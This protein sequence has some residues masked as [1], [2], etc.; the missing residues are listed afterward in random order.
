ML[1]S[2]SSVLRLMLENV[3]LDISQRPSASNLKIDITMGDLTV[4][5]LKTASRASPKLVSTIKKSQ[6]FDSKLLKFSLEINPPEDLDDLDNDKGSLYDRNLSLTT[7]P[8]E[9]IY[10]TKTI[11]ALVDV[12]RSPEEI[13]VDYLQEAAMDGIKEYKDVKMSQVNTRLSLVNTNHVTL[14]SPLIGQY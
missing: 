2:G 12:F 9:I 1:S 7:S 13:N 11:F 3:D 14:Y 6:T 5:G 10:D 4:T 8:L